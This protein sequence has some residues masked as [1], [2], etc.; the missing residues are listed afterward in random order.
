MKTIW[1]DIFH[2]AQLNF[3]LNIIKVLSKNHKIFVTVLGRGK[4]PYIAAK[5]F[6]GTPNIELVIVGNHRGTRLS[7]IFEV[8]VLRLLKLC[9]ILLK[10]RIDLSFSNGYQ[11]ALLSK[12]FCY[13]CVTF[14]DDPHNS[15]GYRLKM[16]FADR[17]YY[18]PYSNRFWKVK[19]PAKILPCL[20]EWAYLSPRYFRPDM[21]VL[22]EYGLVPLKYIFVREISTGT[23]NYATQRSGLVQ[24]IQ[25]EIPSTY[26][27]VLSLED[28]S[29]RHLYP[30][31]WI[32]LEEPVNDF[33]SLIYYCRTLISSGDSMAREGAILGNPSIYIGIRNMPANE[34][35]KD[36]VDFY[37]PAPEDFSD[38]LARCLSDFS[39]ENKRAN[40]DKLNHIFIDINEF[41]LR[42][43]RK[44][45]R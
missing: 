7:A 44:I 29:K 2:P 3:Y 17:S 4:L 35:L 34:V 42:I 19:K 9:F 27:V 13:P 33:Q 18:T 20:K 32:L 8:N 15:I 23:I 25:H 5:E 36:L 12:A 28:K 1:F 14:G 16:F 6:A 24:S 31:N 21:N 45:L 40:I 37:Q 26:K 30:Q 43:T 11:A 39:I 38:L 41:I 10:D 22:H